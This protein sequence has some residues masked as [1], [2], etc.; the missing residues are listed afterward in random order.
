MTIKTKT[1]LKT[2]FE[3]GDRPTQQNYEDLIDSFLH[4]DD[5]PSGGTGNSLTIVGDDFNSY[6][7]VQDSDGSTSALFI[8]SDRVRVG[9]G[10]TANEN[11]NATLTVLSDSSDGI[12]DLASDGDF[13]PRLHIARRNGGSKP[14]H[15][16]E[17]SMDD[18][19]EGL[20]FV[21]NGQTLGGSQ[22]PVFGFDAHGNVH[23]GSDLSPS[24]RMEIVK[25]TSKTNVLHI[26]SSASTPGKLMT[27]KSTGK[28]GFGTSTPNATLHLHQDNADGTT[29]F[30][31]IGD[32]SANNG[33]FIISDENADSNE[34][35]TRI[36]AKSEG[37]MRQGLLI[38]GEASNDDTS[39][40]SVVIRGTFQGG[41]SNDSPILSCQADT[42]EV[43]RITSQG[44]VGINE[45]NPTSIIHVQ[46]MPTFLNN[47]DALNNGMTQGAFY[48]DPSGVLMIVI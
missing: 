28:N 23:V 18:A 38:E 37:N 20:A 3:T 8:K 22:T 30:I 5:A 45:Q 40:A 35:A 2:Y 4:V 13:T 48:A 32:G 29:P 14:N 39:A 21:N 36:Y 31:E 9:L 11:P 25:D 43:L 46:G 7:Q 17:L 1:V 47:T 42:A 19:G 10:S 26:S 15:E 27:V 33:E 6:Q 44:S 34:F 41:P 16:W 12:L 24:A